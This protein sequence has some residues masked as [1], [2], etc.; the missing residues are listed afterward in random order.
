[1]PTESLTQ[2]YTVHREAW[3]CRLRRDQDDDAQLH[4]R[5]QHDVSH[6]PLGP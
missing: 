6:G 5:D 2:F 1:M 3:S 4:T